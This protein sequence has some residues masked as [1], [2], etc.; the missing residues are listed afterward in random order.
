M[1]IL[2]IRRH[3]LHAQFL[4]RWVSLPGEGPV[5][6]LL[7]SK[8]PLRRVLFFFVFLNS[9]DLG[10]FMACADLFFLV[11]L[12]RRPLLCS[13]FPSSSISRFLTM[14]TRVFP[15]RP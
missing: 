6:F 4:T 1:S 9:G 5:N 14:R 11:S 7:A 13:R 12:L 2:A 15:S 3:A 8:R 10:N